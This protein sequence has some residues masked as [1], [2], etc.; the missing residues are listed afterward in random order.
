ML[1]YD[2]K[3]ALS[4]KKITRKSIK[5]KYLKKRRKEYKEQLNNCLRMILKFY[6]NLGVNKAILLKEILKKMRTG[7]WSYIQGLKLSERCLRPFQDLCFFL[8]KQVRCLREDAERKR[9]LR[10]FFFVVGGCLHCHNFLSNLENTVV[11]LNFKK[12]DRQN[13]NKLISMLPV[14]SK[15]FNRIM[16]NQN[17]RNIRKVG[18]DL[19]R[20]SILSRA[21]VSEYLDH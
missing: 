18:D 21:W 14:V 15:I 4:K 11:K 1:Q 6:R 3:V 19:R 7:W 13:Q 8:Q 20:L 9:M 10:L 2:D 12:N 5:R 16:H 17:F